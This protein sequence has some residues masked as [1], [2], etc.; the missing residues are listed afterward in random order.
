MWK[1]IYVRKTWIQIRRLIEGYAR[2]VRTMQTRLACL[3]IPKKKNCEPSI[4]NNPLHLVLLRF[5]DNGPHANTVNMCLLLKL[6]NIKENILRRIKIPKDIKIYTLPKTFAT[7]TQVILDFFQTIIYT[8][9]QIFPSVFL[10]L[11]MTKI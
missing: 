1:I 11:I 7:N 8:C 3:V 6:F 10:I 5:M 2:E 9:L 4:L